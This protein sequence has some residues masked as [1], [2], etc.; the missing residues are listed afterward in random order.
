[1]QWTCDQLLHKQVECGV[2][3]PHYDLALDRS[4]VAACTSANESDDVLI[5]QKGL[6]KLGYRPVFL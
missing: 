4:S 2:I 3:D 5:E 6:N 1:M